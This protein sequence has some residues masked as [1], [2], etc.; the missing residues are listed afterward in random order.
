MTLM[1]PKR[2]KFWQREYTKFKSLKIDIHLNDQLNSS[3]LFS[4]PKCHHINDS[5]PSTDC[6]ACVPRDLFYTPQSSVR[7]RNS[8][9]SINSNDLYVTP[10]DTFESKDLDSTLLQYDLRKSQSCTVV[11]R[12]NMSTIK[13]NQ[14]EVIKSIARSSSVQAVQVVVDSSRVDLLPK[15]E[16]RKVKNEGIFHNI[17]VRSDTIIQNILTPLTKRRA[18]N[19]RSFDSKSLNHSTPNRSSLDNE[20]FKVPGSPITLQPRPISNSPNPTHRAISLG[21][22]RSSSPITINK[23]SSQQNDRFVFYFFFFF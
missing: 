7:K 4:T 16:L 19:S 2:N 9:V 22:L 11:E 6:L 13:E 15:E 23:R 3:D 20:V 8:I 21:S 17:A 1:D 12:T 14:L 5:A 18:L 10:D